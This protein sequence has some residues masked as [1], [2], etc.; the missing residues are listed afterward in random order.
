MLNIDDRGIIFLGRRDFRNMVTKESGH[1][2]SG[3]TVTFT[4]LH[5]GRNTLEPWEKTFQRT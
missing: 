3:Y 1:W 5:S 4:F 2:E